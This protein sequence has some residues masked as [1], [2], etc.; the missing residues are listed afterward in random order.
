[1]QH[2]ARAVDIGL[3]PIVGVCPTQHGSQV[4]AAEAAQRAAEEHFG[5]G[6]SRPEHRV[7]D[8]ASVGDLPAVA[9]DSKGTLAVGIPTPTLAIARR[10][11]MRLI[12]PLERILRQRR[13]RR[14][15]GRR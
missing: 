2:Q 4:G 7:V 12:G 11:P 3:V 9:G 6:G 10:T 8:A 14:R 1:M 13:P 5:I 15:H